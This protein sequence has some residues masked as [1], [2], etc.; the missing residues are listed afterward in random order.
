[1]GSDPIMSG[2]LSVLGFGGGGAMGDQLGTQ[3]EGW[4]RS[5]VRLGRRQDA[6]QFRRLHPQ[7]PFRE[8]RGQAARSSECTKIRPF[9]R[10]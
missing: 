9:T 5:R 10:Y 7:N 4:I 6:I 8:L 1:M 3:A 2:S